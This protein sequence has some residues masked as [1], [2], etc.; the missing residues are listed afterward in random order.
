MTVKDVFETDGLRTT[1]G[2]PELSEYVPD[3]DAVIV[4]RFKAA[5]AVIF[6][7]T[8]TPFL[9]SDGQTYN[10]VF[11]TTINPWDLSRTPGGSSGGCAAAVA[12]GLTSLSVG[13]D[14]G[15]SLRVPACF[16]GI[17]GHKSTFGL[18]PTRGHIP[19]I[20]PGTQ[21]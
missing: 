9:A 7:K 17:L 11:G 5:G 18:V 14:I 2:S 3:R 8:N 6:G 10:N 15:G 12:T 1:A 4:R 20:P 19:P 13:S 16:C 21:R